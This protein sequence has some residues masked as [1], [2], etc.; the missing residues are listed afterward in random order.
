MIKRRLPSSGGR[1][2]DRIM[3][4]VRPLL[5]NSPSSNPSLVGSSFGISLR[6]LLRGYRRPVLSTDRELRSPRS[7]AEL[8]D[9]CRTVR[10]LSDGPG[11]L[12]GRRGT[13]AR[14]NMAVEIHGDG[15]NCGIESD[16][17]FS[18]IDKITGSALVRLAA[19][20]GRALLAVDT[21]RS[22][23]HLHFPRPSLVRGLPSL[24]AWSLSRLRDIRALSPVRFHAA[25]FSR[26][27]RGPLTGQTRH[28]S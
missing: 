16:A 18:P 21:P 12:D 5:I 11:K 24:I 25:P 17:G 6:P 8:R 1:C 22:A 26:K 19:R 7:I 2:D 14:R 28:G 9:A 15:A 4:G 3:E 27:S 20:V 10:Q 23:F 13:R